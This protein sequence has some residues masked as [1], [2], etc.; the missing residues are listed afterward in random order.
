MEP[1]ELQDSLL[2]ELTL[3][4]DNIE[5][6]INAEIKF[7]YT[8]ELDS[9]LVLEFNKEVV[10]TKSNKDFDFC[11][12]EINDNKITKINNQSLS[13]KKARRIIV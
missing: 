9:E 8:T 10:Y 3:R 11:E 6:F 4:Y 7:V 13:Q 2:S 5:E 12:I 1:Q